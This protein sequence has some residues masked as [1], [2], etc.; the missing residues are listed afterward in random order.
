MNTHTKEQNK[1][2]LAGQKITLHKSQ[3]NKKHSGC[4][5]STFYYLN[6]V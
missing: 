1:L 4:I 2:H 5:Y 3:D 6:S